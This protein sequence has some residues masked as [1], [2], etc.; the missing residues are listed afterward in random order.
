MRSLRSTT[1]ASLLLAVLTSFLLA[2]ALTAMPREGRRR[3]DP[4]FVRVVKSL[5]KK[6]SI[7]VHDEG[8]I[9]VPHP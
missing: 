3:D 2:P 4:I 5:L 1:S 8:E 9:G 6:L 7:I